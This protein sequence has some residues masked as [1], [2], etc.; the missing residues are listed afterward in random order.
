MRT[1]RW[2]MVVFAIA[3][4]T[5]LYINLKRLSVSQN[6]P[7]SSPARDHADDAQVAEQA[8]QHRQYE[9]ALAAC[10]SLLRKNPQDIKYLL[11]AG[12]SASRLGRY[13]D[14]IAY[15]DSVPE[16][17]R[18]Q[19]AIARW[20]AGEVHLQRGHLS[21]A[22]ERFE[23]SL[24]SDP[25]HFGARDRLIYLLNLTGQRWEASSHLAHLVQHGQ[26]SV[27]HLL[28]L[29]NIAKPVEN[30]TELQSFLR[31]APTDSLPRLGLARIRLR[32][33]KLD[34][35]E[36]L[37]QQVLQ[38]APG[39]LEA[40]VQ[41]GRLWL[42]QDITQIPAWHQS[43]PAGADQHPEIWMIRGQ[44]ARHDSQTD[45]AARCYAEVLRI[46]PNHR[47]GLN[48]LAQVLHE[49]NQDRLAAPL[50]ER[51]DVLG[52]LVLALERIMSDEWSIRRAMSGTNQGPDPLLTSFL[53]S[54][55][56]LQPIM[57]AARQ[58][59]DLGRSAEA[60]A[61]IQYAQSIAEANPALV[62][63]TLHDRP[64]T[65]LVD[66]DWADKLAWPDWQ[67]NPATQ[68][69]VTAQQPADTAQQPAD[70][71][72]QPADS[73]PRL[74]SGAPSFETISGALDFR[75]FNS[76]TDFEDGRRMFEMTGGG[77]GVLDYDRDGWP[78][79]F[80]AQGC[81][82]PPD[83]TD[84]AHND[85][86]RRNL[87]S[88]PAGARRTANETTTASARQAFQDVTAMAGIVESAFGQ[89]IAIGDINSDG[90]DDVYVC[91]VGVNQ[92]W[93]NQG[94]GT[95]RNAAAQIA[96]PSSA[97]TSSAAIADSN[98]DGTAEIYD[99]NYVEGPDAFT[100]RCFQGGKP[101]TCSPLNFQPAK[102]RLMAVGDDGRYHDVSSRTLDSAV[103]EGNALG[104]VVMRLKDQALPSL[105]VANDQVANLM[106]IVR[107][108]PDA[109]IGIRIDDQAV[110][111]GLAYDGQGNSQ[112]CMGVAADD[113][114]GDG[115][116]D[117]FVTNYYD[118][119]NT[120]YLQQ[121]Q[122][123]FRDATGG[124]GLV[125][126]SVKMLG[127]G[128]QAL[129]A[130][131][132]GTPD[133]VVLNGHIDDLTHVGRPFQMHSQFFAGDGRGRF[134]E[135]AGEGLGAYFQQ[136]RL[137]RALASLDF[138]A[139]GRTD[140]I[141]TALEG[142][143]ELLRNTS[144]AENFLSLQLAGVQSHRDAIGT[145]IVATIGGKTF[146]KQ[147]T[148]GCGYMVTNQKQLL[149]GCGT[150]PTID[151]LDIHWPSGLTQTHHNLPTNSHWLAV[152][153]Q[154]QLTALPLP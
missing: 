102:G 120:L 37:L 145:E 150:A 8:F 64:P 149:F 126:P 4:T 34:E 23:R 25:G 10:Q 117:L 137:G 142:P 99:A 66:L 136:P 103:R 104:L 6:K 128:V 7:S 62:Q 121:A 114:N 84:S 88:P 44:W 78:D 125:A 80:L 71:A 129:D 82:W 77:I 63:P 146:T 61:W 105:F 147:L 42:Q 74:A 68:P 139:D 109:A 28:Y 54:E 18:Q 90:F 21:P 36:R 111:R 107:P 98:A 132:D 57:A 19:A 108:D 122:G 144:P 69:A 89:G 39:L 118:E 133:L 70:S 131:L 59:R 55:K 154:T 141:A 75:F 119:S 97:W 148:A 58:T 113:L 112:A 81:V 65:L 92:L 130:Q 14:A 106:L 87:G 94:D 40:H 53:H 45:A 22:M 83:G 26:W 52:Q 123:S 100:R 24:E 31:A 27:Q 56:R 30:E 127:F 1:L 32:A 138:D 9:I 79:V 115:T 134:T 60:N 135:P 3:L 50:L 85:Q 51:A 2:Y 72:Q 73:A 46:D 116:L 151:Q 67:T 91:N 124:S 43:L 20:A 33:G 93:I 5:L 38:Q 15:Y 48:A 101:R 86:L 41:L 140:L 76:R 152:E 143:T 110:L 29:G 96:K 47:A 16:T 35:A 17:H 11:I 49:R 13:T 95:F 153:N 12:E